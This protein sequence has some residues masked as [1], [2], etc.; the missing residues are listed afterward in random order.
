MVSH[1]TPSAAAQ[2]VAWGKLLFPQR[3]F[4]RLAHT[5]SLGISSL[6]IIIKLAFAL[7][8]EVVSHRFLAEGFTIS[9]G[10]VTYFPVAVEFD[11]FLDAKRPNVSDKDFVG[12][13]LALVNRLTAYVKVHVVGTTRQRQRG[14]GGGRGGWGGWRR[15]GW[16]GRG[17][18]RRGH[19]SSRSA[20]NTITDR[21]G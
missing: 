7:K 18:G 2:F 12:R 21:E 3:L 15:G 5:V 19:G 10:F 17:R 20:S 6:E 16:G 11:L 13:Y 4:P 14:G 1:F 8:I 9:A